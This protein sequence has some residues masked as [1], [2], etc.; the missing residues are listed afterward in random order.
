MHMATTAANKPSGPRLFLVRVCLI[1][2][3]VWTQSLIRDPGIA[4]AEPASTGAVT[5]ERLDFNVHWKGV[6]A[7]RAS[8]AY[9]TTGDPAKGDF[10]YTIKA[11]LVSIGPVDWIYGVNDVITARGVRNAW[12]LTT[13]NYLKLQNQGRRQRRVDYDFQ[14]DKDQVVL[15]KNDDPPKI[16]DNISDNISDPMT[17]FY[18]LRSQTDLKPGA[19]KIHLP[20]LDSDRWYMAEVTTGPAEDLFTPLGWFQVFPIHPLLQASELFRQQGDLTIWVTHDERR[21][22]LRVATKVRI[23]QVTAELIGFVDGRG[24]SQALHDQPAVPENARPGGTP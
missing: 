17:V 16:L 15:R 5:G 24:H 20:V 23:G 1:Q 18:Q 4:R 9:D 8:L 21:L 19:G 12:G 2:L 14:R 7:G 11:N 22:P 13:L 3:L 10:Q 6:P